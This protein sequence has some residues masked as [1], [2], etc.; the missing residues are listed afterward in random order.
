MSR[1]P[2]SGDAARQSESI[3][4]DV[5]LHHEPHH[6]HAMS[7]NRLYLIP[8]A[9]LA[10][11]LL[12]PGCARVMSTVGSTTARFL[13]QSTDDL[14]K[15]NRMIGYVDNAYPAATQEAGVMAIGGK[16]QE[17][18]P[19]ASVT[20][21]KRNGIGMWKLNG[22]MTA[23]G[24]PMDSYAGGV[25]RFLFLDDRNPVTVALTSESGQTEEYRIDPLPPIRITA[26]NGQ[27][28]GR[29]METAVAL[30]LEGPLT[31]DIDRQNLGRATDMR[32]ALQGTTMGV[33]GFWDVA[34]VPGQNRIELPAGVF[35]NGQGNPINT[36]E[37]WLLLEEYERP[38][39]ENAQGGGMVLKAVKSADVVP[40]I[41]SG[42]LPRNL[43]G[44]IKGGFTVEEEAE[45]QDGDA[46]SYSFTKPPAFA[47]PAFLPG[48][49]LALVTF[50]VRANDLSQEKSSTST[51]ENRVQ[52]TRTTTTT[53]RSRQFAQLPTAFY[54][55]LANDMHGDLMSAMQGAWNVEMI[56]ISQ[57]LAS[58]RYQQ[59]DAVR[60][61]STS[62]Y[63]SASYGGLRTIFDPSPWATLSAGDLS[64]P[65]SMA[66]RERLMDELGV[67]GL[68]AV[69]IDLSMPWSEFS[70]TPTINLHITGRTAD[71]MQPAASY[72]AKGIVTGEGQDMAGVDM[73][74][75]AQL[76]AFLDNA[77]NRDLLAT[78][79]GIGF[80]RLVEEE[81]VRPIYAAVW[82]GR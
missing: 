5:T 78:T 47:G 69:T 59:F 75:P 81:R 4:L 36:G 6:T 30:D 74:D 24:A 10:V 72:F 9:A 26:V 48:T 21:M 38:T 18:K 27:P 37:N 71:L 7:R 55:Q 31:L 73:D 79:F 23:N 56:P 57:V 54:Q 68:V 46:F 39:F 76:R 62:E 12:L 43:V 51:T 11:V 44:L 52:G 33:K 61:T 49:K 41:T 42:E 20:L 19:T 3:V 1:I 70:L 40:V 67:D 45:T 28:V 80:N 35:S 17:G 29:T 77:V 25:S 82:E 2:E 50:T 8:L 64:G 53:T 65:F 63:A 16:H 13:T 14:S 66:D 32:I 15:S 34:V 58:P 22:E 60:D